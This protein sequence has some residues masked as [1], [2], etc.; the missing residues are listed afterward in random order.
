MSRRRLRFNRP[1]AT[2][3]AGCLLPDAIQ[4]PTRSGCVSAEAG[5]IVHTIREDELTSEE[6]QNVRAACEQGA[7]K[8]AHLTGIRSDLV[9]SD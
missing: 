5:R 9:V 6:L 7:W 2:V 1:A 4:S 8:L 3:P